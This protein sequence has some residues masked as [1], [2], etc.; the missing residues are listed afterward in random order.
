VRIGGWRNYICYWLLMMLFALMRCGWFV[1]GRGL[2][3]VMATLC[4]ARGG[5]GYSARARDSKAWRWRSRLK[6]ALPRETR[7]LSGVAD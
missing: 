5:W 3:V 2:R 1:P 4:I 7:T 6:L